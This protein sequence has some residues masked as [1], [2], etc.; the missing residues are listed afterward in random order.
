MMA[1]QVAPGVR[2]RRADGLST[3]SP[4]EE[5]R[6]AEVKVCAALRLEQR[7]IERGH[8]TPVDSPAS[9]LVA[10]RQLLGV[11]G[12]TRTEVLEQLTSRLGLV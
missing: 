10:A 4:Y 11:V 1:T 3:L 6:L 5:Q 8:Y 7:L 2:R 9:A 12:G